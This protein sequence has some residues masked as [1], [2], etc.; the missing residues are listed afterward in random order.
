MNKNI[1]LAIFYFFASTIITCWFIDKGE[2]LYISTNKMIASC[3]IAGAKWA[4]Q[5]VVAFILLKEKKWQFIKSIGLTCLIGSCI[6]LPYCIFESIR[7][8]EKSF[9]S[10]L[11]L[12]VGIMI[13][14]YYYAVKKTKISIVWFWSWMICL[15]IAISLQVFYIFKLN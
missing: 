9:L 4:I 1:L 7:K 5:I 10:S 12:A 13:P 8:I 6:L 2:L 14:T 3:T 11:I 15:T